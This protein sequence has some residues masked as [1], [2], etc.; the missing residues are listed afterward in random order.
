MLYFLDKFKFTAR[1]PTSLALVID[2]ITR[3]TQCP[4]RYTVL[5]ADAFLAS[6]RKN[7]L[8]KLV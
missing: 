7:D 1:I 4:A 6:N 8:E 5:Y 2:T 3:G